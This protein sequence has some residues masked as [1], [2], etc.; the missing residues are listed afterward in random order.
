MEEKLQLDY[1]INPN[2]KLYQHKDHFHTNTDTKILAQFVKIKKNDRVLD[3]GTNN[4]AILRYIDQFDVKELVGVEALEESYHIACLNA[5]TFFQHSYKIEHSKIQ[6]YNDDLFDCI[7]SNPP[8]FQESA[9][10]KNTQITLRQMG[11]IEKN[12]TL[13]ELIMHANRLLKSN[14]RFYFVHRP[15]RLNEIYALLLQYNFNVKTFQT[16]YDRRTNRI[17][18]ILI[19]AVKDSNCDCVILPSIEL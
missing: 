16:F 3:I 1:F 15:N 4:G 11:R 6:D 18:S 2:L 10:H 12:L 7:I 9:T 17:K 19:E 8:Y 5:K 13:E 14:G